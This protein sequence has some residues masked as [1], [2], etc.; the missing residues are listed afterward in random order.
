MSSRL[1]SV[2][3]TMKYPPTQATILATRHPPQCQPKAV[4]RPLQNHAMTRRSNQ[5]STRPSQSHTIPPKP[6]NIFHALSKITYGNIYI[7]DTCSHLVWSTQPT[8]CG[9]C[10]CRYQTL[11]NGPIVGIGAIQ[12]C[13]HGGCYVSTTRVIGKK[14]HNEWTRKIH[15][16]ISYQR[17]AAAYWSTYDNLS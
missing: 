13:Q 15:Q 5:N 2:L 12:H 4:R 6:R 8:Q 3:Q 16:Y 1:W 11:P 7:L 9:Q 10:A 17:V 14:V